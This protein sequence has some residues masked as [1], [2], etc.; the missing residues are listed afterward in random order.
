MRTFRHTG[1]TTHLLVILLNPWWWIIIQR[2]FLAGLL[3][4]SLSLVLYLY[5]WQIESRVL[6]ILLVIFTLI[7]FFLSV[8][9]AF[10]ESIFRNSALDIQQYNKRHEFYSND[11]GKL[12]K[13]RFI[14][15]YF[16]DYNFPISKIQRNF[17]NNLDPNLYFFASHPRERLGI[18]EFQKYLP[19][20][21]PLFLIGMF[22]FI[23][24]PVTKILIYLISV[25]LLSSIIS[26]KY[27]LGPVLIFPFINL[28]ITIGIILSWKKVLRYFLKK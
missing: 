3:V 2:N 23:F 22:H 20:F 13:N 11:L 1:L 26:P 19:I 6:L 5:F 8:R 27:N 25:F 18:E 9:A 12:Y 4:F 15:T 16:K 7:L 10:D 28:M 24:A 21:L 14:L 17:F